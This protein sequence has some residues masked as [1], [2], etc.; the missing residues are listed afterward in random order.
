MFAL[1]FL[2]RKKAEKG[3]TDI[4]HS[5]SSPLQFFSTLFAPLGF[6]A[7]KMESFMPSSFWHQLTRIWARTRRRKKKAFA[8]LSSAS[9][10]TRC[11]VTDYVNWGCINTAI[12]LG[13]WSPTPFQRPEFFHSHI[14][15][16]VKMSFTILLQ[17]H[18]VG[19]TLARSDF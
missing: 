2:S 19:M 16:N 4:R 18:H 3:F 13:W 12:A 1:T 9:P 11:I 5:A 10:S 15:K 8:L 14:K 7:D 6:F 17:G